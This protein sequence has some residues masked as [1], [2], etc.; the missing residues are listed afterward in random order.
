MTAA[1]ENIAERPDRVPR[2]VYLITPDWANTDRL[3]TVV[4]AAIRGGAAAIQY[5]NKSAGADL[6]RAQSRALAHLTQSAGLPFFVDDDA[7]LAIEVGADGLHIGRA[8]GDPAEVRAKLPPAMMLGV[9]C[10]ADLALVAQAVRIGAAYVALGAMAASRTKPAAG[11]GPLECIGQARR[12]GAHVVAS[13]GIS[14]ANIEQVAA[15]GARAVG[16]VSAVFDASDPMNATA[17][18]VAGFALGAQRT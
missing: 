14:R 13:G 9:S 11:I 5:R 16:V 12:L 2:G 8:D 1:L 18:L 6:R 15:A 17:E 3:E 7:A 4:A 10:Y